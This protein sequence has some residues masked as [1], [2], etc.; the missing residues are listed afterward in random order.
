[1]ILP[2]LMYL[3]QPNGRS[4]YIDVVQGRERFECI[5]ENGRDDTSSNFLIGLSDLRY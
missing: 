1:M 5:V 2:I 3:V 4:G